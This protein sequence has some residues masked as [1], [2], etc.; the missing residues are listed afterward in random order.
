MCFSA[1][2]RR[3][4]SLAA[5]EEIFLLASAPVRPAR[6]RSKQDQKKM[7]NSCWKQQTPFLNDSPPRSY[8][9]PYET[10][11]LPFLDDREQ[12]HREPPDSTPAPA[13]SMKVPAVLS[14]EAQHA[15]LSDADTT[16]A[17]FLPERRGARFDLRAPRMVRTRE[18]GLSRPRKRGRRRRRTRVGLTAC[19]NGL[20]LTA[21][22]QARPWRRGSVGL[23][24]T[25]T[26]V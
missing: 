12:D 3:A 5:L 10:F 20:T 15:P 18:G 6:C 1:Q 17:S 25:S 21:S 13:S 2:H 9:I 16:A 7:S 14:R 8:A 23:Q 19:A 11:F 26:A 4:C 24:A 22:R